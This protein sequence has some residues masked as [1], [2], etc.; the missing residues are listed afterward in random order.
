MAPR[1]ISRCCTAR[2]D[3]RGAAAA[4]LDG[5][6]VRRA[7]RT[8]PAIVAFADLESPDA[9]Q[10]LRAQKAFARVRGIRQ[11]LNWHHDPR[12][13]RAPTDHLA[14]RTWRRNFALLGEMG[15]SFDAQVYPF[16]LCRLAELASGT[17]TP[18]VLDHCGLPAADLS[19]R[20]V[21][22]AGIRELARV[23]HIHAKISGFGMTDG[24]VD[25]AGAA[26][27]IAELID[28]FGTDRGSN[29]PV[30][31]LR[32]TYAGLWEFF[33]G[34]LKDYPVAEQQTMLSGNAR[35]FYRLT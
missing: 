18:V 15:L 5:R 33:A 8:D 28:T 12:L 11:V 16:Q 27:R 25:R 10:A 30:D 35:R 23:P 14:S 17:G 6:T 34:V 13:S 29:F 21:W 4:D 2:P 24:A 22:R 26:D 3:A 1:R 19:D 20:D 32:F 7:R 31:R 9:G